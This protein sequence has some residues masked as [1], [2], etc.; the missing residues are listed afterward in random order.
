MPVFLKRDL[1]EQLP[2]LKKQN[3]HHKDYATRSVSEL[4]SA[5]VMSKSVEKDFTYGGSCIAWNQGGGQF[6]VEKLPAMTQMSSVNAVVV[7]DVNAD[8]RK[9]LVMGGNR[10][11]FPPQFGRLDGSYGDVVVNEGGRKLK[12]IEP[13]KSGILVK[14]E[15]REI[16]EIRRADGS[17]LIIYL[18]NDDY[19]KAFSFGRTNIQKQD[20]NK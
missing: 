9:D 6:Q 4:F 13:V 14:G 19:P 11:G 1:E 7:E 3:L 18:I 2:I 12:W 16:K 5:E 15:V 17:K 10:Y 20:P 8:G